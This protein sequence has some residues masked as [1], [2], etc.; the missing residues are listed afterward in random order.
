MLRLPPHFLGAS[1]QNINS[2]TPHTGEWLD[3]LHSSFSI[4]NSLHH[5]NFH[6]AILRSSSFSTIISHR[7]SIPFTDTPNS[8]SR[9]ATRCQQRSYFCRTFFRQYL[10][11]REFSGVDRLAVRVAGHRHRAPHT[12]NL[13]RALSITGR[14]A[15][16]TVFC[17]GINIVSP[18]KITRL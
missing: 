10:V 16:F 9:N 1:F 13:T 3:A 7:H 12:R 6:P 18:R 8:A 11:G 4:I 15:S 17:P 5:Q 2:V 14:S